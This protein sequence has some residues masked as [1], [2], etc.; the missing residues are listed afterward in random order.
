MGQDP[1]IFYLLSKKI[2]NKGIIFILFKDKINKFF[3]KWKNQ[4]RMKIHQS[5]NH[6]IYDM[7]SFVKSLELVKLCI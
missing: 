1:K 6:I 7:I 2:V 5:L 3:S 4:I